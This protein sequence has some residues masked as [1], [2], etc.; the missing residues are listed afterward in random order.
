M[1]RQ[2]HSVN[3]DRAQPQAL[4]NVVDGVF[5]MAGMVIG[6]GIFKAPSV[7]AAGANTAAEFLWAWLAGGVLSLCGA[8]VYAELSARHP[9]TGGEYAFLARAFG[10]GTAFVFAW[11][12]I[13]VIQTGAIAAVGFVYG[14]YAQQIVPLPGAGAAWHAALALIALTALNVLGTP[15]TRNLQKVMETL[16]VLGLI[17]L[18]VGGLLLRAPIETT[19]QSATGSWGLAM[20]FVLLTYGGWNEAAYLAGEVKDA[21]R[22]MTR[23]LVIGIVLVTALYL[24]VNAGYLA[25][26]GLQ[27][28]RDSQAVGADVMRLI[29]GDRGAIALA[30]I[31]CVSALTTMNAAILT[32]ARSSYALG[33]DFRLFAAL[34][35]WSERGSTPVTALLW[36]A[37][38]TGVLIAA[39]AFTRDGFSAMVAYTAP[40]FWVFFLLTGLTLFVFRA[41][42]TQAFTGFRVPL[43]PVVPLVFCAT[44]AWM[45][46]S[47]IEFVRGPYGPS[48]GVAVLAGIAVMLAGLPLYI[49]ARRG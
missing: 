41:R 8:L 11:S 40:V 20:I 15:Q 17:A 28:V 3:H 13:S 35:R 32:G 31:V 19:P 39:S 48:F 14:D 7:V 23:I 24:L 29:A 42:Q 1:D 27:G 16:L 34:G 12:R 10:G 33:R 4:L 30:L 45:L 46:Y 22:N 37:A 6:V 9:E 2:T 38:I 43:F 18:A 26:L 36:Q 25:A 49:W 5:L 47:S 21:Q 44:C